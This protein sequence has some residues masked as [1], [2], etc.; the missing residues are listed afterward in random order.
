MM[1]ASFSIS[2]TQVNLDDLLQLQTLAVDLKKLNAKPAR[3]RLLGEQRSRFRGMGRE[4]IEMK[5]Y[6]PGDDV[7]QIDWRL[8]AKKQTPYV[9]VMEEDRH[10]EHVIWL[11]LQASQYFGTERCFKSV[12][13]CHWTAFLVWRFVQLKHPVRLFIDVGTDWQTE[14]A[15][16]SLHH[17]AEACR[18]IA[19]AHQHLANHYQDMVEDTALTLPHWRAN[20]T[21]W[22]V[23]DFLPNTLRATEAAVAS[24]PITALNCLQPVDRFDEALPDSGALP[25]RHRQSTRVIQ[26]SDP[27]TALQ[28]KH[29]FQQRNE[30]LDTLCRQY[31]GVHI[32]ESVASF[33]WQ[34]VQQWPLYH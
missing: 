30:R 34:E 21:L 7:R 25:V 16:T 13:A 3:S 18:K 11:P 20:P 15:I 24:K 9:R 29:Q 8:T 31:Q 6:Q 2:G 32:S 33:N 14:I 4:F 1:N 5:S 23:S 26:T 12:M 19:E 28:Y 10:S 17:A 22:V 27:Q